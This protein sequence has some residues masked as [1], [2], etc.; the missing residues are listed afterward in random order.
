[1]GWLLAWI[2]FAYRRIN[3]GGLLVRTRLTAYE[4]LVDQAILNRFLS[5]KNL[6]AFDVARDLFMALGCVMSEHGLQERAHTHNLF[7]L[8]LDIRTLSATL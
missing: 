2:L 1:M 5:S 4:N 7:G 8:D 3:G 6:V